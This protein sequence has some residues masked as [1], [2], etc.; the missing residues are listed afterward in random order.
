M[1]SNRTV[2]LVTRD[3]LRHTTFDEYDLMQTGTLAGPESPDG[4]AIRSDLLPPGT[5]G[6]N[7][8][9]LV[10]RKVWDALRIPVCTAAG[11]RCEIC[12][13]QAIRNGRIGRPY[14][15][16]KWTFEF[17]ADRPI[18]C[19]QRLIAPCP[20]CHQVQHSGLAPSKRPGARGYRATVPPEP[21][22]PPASPQLITRAEV[23]QV[24]DSGFVKASDVCSGDVKSACTE[25]GIA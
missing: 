10:D 3:M 20:G 18:E 25:L 9:G 14:C 24:V 13:D 19:L 21:L 7:V 2:L 15:H 4:V 1:N 12:G 22:V 5:H 6:S 16:E 23:K 11:D 8:R 17:R